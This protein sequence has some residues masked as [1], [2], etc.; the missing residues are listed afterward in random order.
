[1]KNLIFKTLVII[2]FSGSILV[3]WAWKEFEL[4]MTSKVSLPKDGL[5]FEVTSGMS[6]Y[7]VAN[8]LRRQ[9][10]GPNPNWQR[11]IAW[12]YPE[13]TQ[14]KVAEYQIESDQSYYEVLKQL[15]TGVGKQYEIQLIEGITFKEALGV[16]ASNEQLNQDI[17]LDVLSVRE[18]LAIEADNP[19]GWL[20]PDTY[21]FPKNTNASE[22]LKIM[23]R[24]LVQSL[25]TAWQNRA[26]DNELANPTELLIMASLIEKEAAIDSERTIISGVFHRRLAKRMRL[27]TDPT[28]IYAMGDEFN[29]DIRRKDLLRQ[30]PYNTYRVFGL[31]PTPIALP[32]LASLEAAANPAPGSSLYFVARGDGSHAFSNT[33]EEHNAA[34]RKYQ[35]RK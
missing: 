30:S 6:F 13:L 21:Q 9:S 17:A 31:P 34:V 8:E 19:E 11:L 12:Y 5:A 20:F 4:I 23:H 26:L 10:I 32:S 15:T 33:L 7:T 3:G 18:L 25:D 24:R 14:I 27:Q 1:M 2:I 28:V 35:L 29:G 16:I 22:L